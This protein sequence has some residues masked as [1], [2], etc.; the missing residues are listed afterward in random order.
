M[1]YCAESLQWKTEISKL[2]AYYFPRQ[3]E[4]SY[5]KAEM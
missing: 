1:S 5:H 4:C 2:G 3:E